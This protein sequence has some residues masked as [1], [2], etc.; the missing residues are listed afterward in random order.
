MIYFDNA[1]TSLRKPDKVYKAFSDAIKS[2]ANPGRGSYP[3]SMKAAEI[4]YSCREEAARFF[5]LSEPERIIFTHNTTHALNLA[6][7]GVMADGGHC[8]ISGYEHNSVARPIEAM[9]ENGIITYSVADA[10]LFKPQE[11]VRA[12]AS[13]ITGQTKY[14]IVNHVSNVFGYMLP[15]YELNEVCEQ[16]GIGMVLDAAQSAGILPID[17]ERLTACEYIC[18]PGHKGLYGPQGTGIL[19][20]L[21]DKK[22]KTIIE[23]GTGSVSNDLRQPTFLPDRFESGTMNVPGIAGLTEGI[24]FVKK[25]G[26][27][28]IRAHE[29]NLLKYVKEGLS[30]IPGVELFA[31]DAAVHQTG[32]LSFRARKSCEEIADALSKSGICVRAGLHCA[33]YAHKNAGTFGTGTVRVSFSYFNTIG[34][35][36]KFLIEIKKFLFGK[37][38]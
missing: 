28:A 14:F 1:A 22:H 6:I 18:M 17:Y 11:M 9:A 13:R 15:I 20:C 5:H 23:G 33:P 37:K 31:A 32:V 27:E 19:I 8:V 36:E 30:V 21:K 38:N 7:K 34:E 25:T 3:P 2:A 29:Q 12:F 16:N 24:R 4:V 26:M 35:A 10:P